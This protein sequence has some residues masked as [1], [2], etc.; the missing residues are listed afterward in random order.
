[1]SSTLQRLSS[2]ASQLPPLGS[3]NTSP[4]PHIH[5]LSPTHFLP[6]AATIEPHARSVY[7]RTSTGRIITYTYA[8]T[9]RRAAGLTYYLRRRSLKRVGILAA[10]TPAFLES[11]FAIGG[12]GGVN[13][14]INYRLKAEDVAYIFD[15]AEVDAVIVDSEFE[16]LLQPFRQ[17]HPA[18]QILVD[19]DDDGHN[20][21]YED[22]VREGL[23]Y[24][25]E[26]GGHGWEGLETQVADEDGMFALSYTS[27]TTAR[28]KGVEYTHRGAYLASLANV[29]ESDL[30]YCRPGADRCHYL[31]TLPMFHA[32]GWTFPWAVT[33]V[34][35]THFTLRKIEYAEIWRLLRDE[36][37]SHFNAAPT[38]NT[39]LCSDG[40]ARKLDG[41]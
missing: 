35:G 8:D 15:H 14:A 39:L 17:S 22:A 38:V 27:G 1:M 40:N 23:R 18:V 10:N 3:N 28:P 33:A 7:H 32:T 26:L 4:K 34:R 36:S 21:P 5:Q 37:I 24:D 29:V 25:E 20:G 13:V 6:R 19:N 2:L 12:A 30:N 41:K 11:F 31:W 16:D 9:A